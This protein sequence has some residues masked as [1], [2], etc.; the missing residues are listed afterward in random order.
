MKTPEEMKRM[1][2]AVAKTPTPS[3]VGSVDPLQ[4]MQILQ[5]HQTR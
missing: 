3:K 1:D 4:L 5:V 2:D